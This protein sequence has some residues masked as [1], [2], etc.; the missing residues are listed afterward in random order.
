V[1]PIAFSTR[2]DNINSEHEYTLFAHLAV[3]E[4]DRSLKCPPRRIIM[5]RLHQEDT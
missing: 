4:F 3:S 5:I 2:P 1:S